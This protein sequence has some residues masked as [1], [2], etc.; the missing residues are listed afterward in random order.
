MFSFSLFCVGACEFCL[1]LIVVVRLSLSL[2]VCFSCMDIGT[3]L[4]RQETAAVLGLCTRPLVCVSVLVH[5]SHFVCCS[6]LF[7]MFSVGV[8]MGYVFSCMGPKHAETDEMFADQWDP[9]QH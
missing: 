1:C 6:S 2:R 4:S 3:A 8:F 5:S 7:S 9:Q